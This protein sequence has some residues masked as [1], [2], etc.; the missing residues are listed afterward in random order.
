MAG[1]NSVRPCT[2][3]KKEP[4]IPKYWSYRTDYRPMKVIS[5]VMSHMG[6]NNNVLL[7]LYFQ[8]SCGSVNI[9]IWRLGNPFASIP[10]TVFLL[11]C[12]AFVKR[13]MN[14]E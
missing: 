9:L 10:F 2:L 4:K 1:R 11:F 7:T 5:R 13:F 14:I 6:E 12:L 3:V 8:R